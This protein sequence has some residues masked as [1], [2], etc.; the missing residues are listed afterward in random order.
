MI[1]ATV[2]LVIAHLVI[3]RLRQR[4]ASD[5]H[6][7][8]AIALGVATVLPLLSILLPAWQPAWASRMAEWPTSLGAFRA[9]STGEGADVVVRA[10]G[11]EAAGWTLSL[12]AV[13][14]W[15]WV[16]G[17]LV[18]LVA[19]GRDAVR[20]VRVVRGAKPVGDSRMLRTCADAARSLGLTRTPVLL[21]GDQTMVPMT[22]GIRRPHVLL[23]VG[24]FEWPDDRL[25]AVCAHELAHV[26]RAD[27][28]VHVLAQMVCAVYWF[29][30]LFWMAERALGRESEQAADDE[31]VASG[32]DASQYA[33]H[34]VALVRQMRAPLAV[35][36]PVVAM[37]RPS[38][39]ERRVAALLRADANRTLVS[40]RRAL[41]AA[42]A[43]AVLVIPLATVAAGREWFDVDVRTVEPPSMLRSSGAR[44][45]EP[46]LPIVRAV[47]GASPFGAG[48]A[49]GAGRAGSFGAGGAGRFATG[50]EDTLPAIAEFT[51]PPL[52]SDVARR[53]H[54]EGVVTIG[55]H[56]DEDG[57]LSVARVVKGLGAGLDQNALVAVRQW[58]FVPGSR[59]GR[60]AA[61]D[62]EIDIEF[63]LQN[64]AVN[65]LIAN[66]MATLVGPDVIP[67]RA[68][69]TS[70]APLDAGPARGSVV[71]DVVLLQDGSPKIVRILQ[72][73][74]PEADEQAV[75]HFEQWRFTPAMRNG[76]PVKV[77]M[78]AEVR[79]HG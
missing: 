9:W 70:R 65:E 48:G 62:A 35:R 45:A 56:V 74:T 66:D 72:S 21:H 37:G 14:V 7:C 57:R 77:R 51:T 63:S 44:D 59:A 38:Q 41:L 55:V 73:L 25:H 23:P 28:L 8:W 32:L 10:T 13:W 24:A 39:L 78:N 46:M 12:A 53:R 36:A 60:R 52:Y 47:G 71:L 22:W 64:E 61:M 15:V 40:P 34:V 19:L 16:G 54:I 11:I 5:R 30:P 27:W 29:N 2:V 42:V 69:R 3:P 75:R 1:R 33:A 43:S 49:G 18:A 50:G 67:P 17:S 6:L 76:A 20:L 4:S 58:R 79:F 26:R 31:A 68:V